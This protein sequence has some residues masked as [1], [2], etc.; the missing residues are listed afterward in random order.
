MNTINSRIREVRKKFCNDSNVDFA[1]RLNKKPN[2]TSN[3]VHEG[4]SVG[5]S[6]ANEIA[7][8]F[9]ISISW[10]LTGDGEMLNSAPKTDNA[11]SGTVT[12]PLLPYGVMAGTPGNDVDGI[13]LEECEQYTIP[14]FSAKGARF[15]ARVD[16][17]SMYPR[18]SSGDLLACR[19]LEDPHFIQW[20]RIYV[21]DTTQGPL[22]KR[23]FPCPGDD[24]KIRCHS[25]NTEKFPDFDIPKEDVRQMALVVGYLGME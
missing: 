9:N 12:L 23:L 25:E 4:Y 16:G 8:K 2:V 1:K 3:W 14:S 10:L 13:N 5:G 20:G 17:L 11:S 7:K 19:I 24:T 6:V 22:V 18:F 15:L 21:M